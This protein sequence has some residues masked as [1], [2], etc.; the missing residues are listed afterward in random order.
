M[1]PWEDRRRRRKAFLQNV[2]LRRP[3]A[4]KRAQLFSGPGSQFFSYLIGK[5]VYWVHAQF[6]TQTVCS[7]AIDHEEWTNS[8]RIAV[9]RMNLPTG[10]QWCLSPGVYPSSFLTHNQK[11]YI[12][13]SQIANIT[14]YDGAATPVSHT[15]VAVDVAREGRKVR[16]RWR[17]QL[18]GVPV[19]AQVNAEVALEKLPSGV[20]RTEMRVAVPVMETVSGQN[21]AG[22]TAAPK[23]AYT[24][25]LVLTGFFHERSDVAGRRLVKQIVAN[26]LNNTSTSVAAVT[27]GPA[28]DLIDGLVAPT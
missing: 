2:R 17:E 4:Q 1:R 19:D 6:V 12:F 21:A 18:A 15:L 22:Y 20:Y 27:N 24:N 5:G 23:V 10:N 16:A 8:D 7:L 13:M 14:V 25:T 28:S 11:G 3:V 26:L 9:A